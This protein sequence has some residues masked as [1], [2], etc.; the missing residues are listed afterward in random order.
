MKKIL[1]LFGLAL[2]LVTHQANAITINII[3]DTD[4]RLHFSVDWSTPGDGDSGI[5]PGPGISIVQATDLGATAVDVA[6]GRLPPTGPL[7]FE[8][9][10]IYHVAVPPDDVRVVGFGGV[11]NNFSP[12]STSAEFAY[13]ATP[14]AGVPDGGATFGMLALAGFGVMG[15]RRKL[16]S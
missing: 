8:G 15:L 14:V 10:T 2:T 9:F 5:S 1:C 6:V 13:G 16:T 3:E 12:G 4:T 11:W 7:Y